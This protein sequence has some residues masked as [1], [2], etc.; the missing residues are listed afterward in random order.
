MRELTFVGIRVQALLMLL[1]ELLDTSPRL[2]RLFP[3]SQV[4]THALPDIQNWISLCLLL[5]NHY[6]IVK[7]IQFC[8]Y[9]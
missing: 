7:L 9:C 4:E 3:N 1:E 2:L 6:L 5:P 8:Y